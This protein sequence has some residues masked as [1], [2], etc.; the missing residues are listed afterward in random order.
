MVTIVWGDLGEV[1]EVGPSTEEPWDCRF[2]AQC[3]CSLA[4][5]WCRGLAPAHP[6][7]FFLFKHE[8]AP[9]RTP[10]WACAHEPA[11]F[12]GGCA[13]GSVSDYREMALSRNVPPI[14]PR[15]ARNPYV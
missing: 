11:R 5:S 3:R 14:P 15:Q 10:I 8:L 7:C 9:F 13:A 6:G 4:S 2:D 12:F 1:R